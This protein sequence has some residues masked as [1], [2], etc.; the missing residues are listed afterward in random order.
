MLL[1]GDVGGTKTLIGVFRRDSVRPAAVDIRTYRTLDFP[2]LGALALDFVKDAGTAAR[3]IDAACFGVAGPVTGTSARLTNIP[4]VVE[5]GAMCRDLSVPRTYLLNDLEAL[6]WSVSVLEPDEI[7]V[8][9][10]GEPDE[11]GGA[12]LLAAGTGL[13]MALLPKI[14]GRF[15]PRPSEG[16]HVDFAARNPPEQL[17]RNALIEEYARAELERVVSGPGLANIH[18]FVHPHRCA[19]LTQPPDSRE[20]PALVTRAALED[21]CRD[22]L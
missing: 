21:G 17:L 22:C 1:A 19:A 6:A 3:E 12:A 8:L 9:L 4:W 20:F 7:E 13:G 14:D 18:R 15:V 2:N 5:A 16:G 11:S 10:E